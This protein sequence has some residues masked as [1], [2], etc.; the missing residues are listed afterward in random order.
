MCSVVIA[1]AP[2]GGQ[3]KFHCL[4]SPWFWTQVLVEAHRQDHNLLLLKH[5]DLFM[6]HTCKFYGCRKALPAF[7]SL[8]WSAH[9]PVTGFLWAYGTEERTC[10]HEIFLPKI[11]V[12][13]W[14][15]N[16]KTLSAVILQYFTSVSI[17]KCYKYT[18]SFME[19]G[20]KFYKQLP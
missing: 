6:G 20:S 18:G 11:A 17:V 12:V 4:S 13:P 15:L 5:L 10:A 8:F 3:Q 16:R 9:A 7:L 1:L 19:S 14:C 2:H